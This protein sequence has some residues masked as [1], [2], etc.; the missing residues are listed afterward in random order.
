MTKINVTNNDIKNGRR[1]SGTKCPVAR[2]ISRHLR[3][4]MY[5]TKFVVLEKYLSLVNE[6][7]RNILPLYGLSIH[8]PNKVTEFIIRFDTQEKRRKFYPFTFNLDIPKWALK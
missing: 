3:K 4:G 7:K 1:R 6:R 5:P 2:A 8:F